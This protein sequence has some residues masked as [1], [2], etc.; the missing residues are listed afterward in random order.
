VSIFRPEGPKRLGATLSPNSIV[1]PL[2]ARPKNLLCFIT[3]QSG[4]E[5]SGVPA[6]SAVVFR[7]HFLCNVSRTKRFPE[8]VEL[9]SAA[10]PVTVVERGYQFLTFTCFGRPWPQAKQ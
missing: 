6:H 1:T 3:V 5:F 9:C 4:S 10:N 7:R 2:A 8:P